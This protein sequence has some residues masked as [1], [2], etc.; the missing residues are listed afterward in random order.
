MKRANAQRRADLSGPARRFLFLGSAMS[1]MPAV[2]MLTFESH[3]WRN[4]VCL[5]WLFLESCFCRSQRGFVGCEL[6][7]ARL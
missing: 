5:A 6:D 3:D 7:L 1:P 2:A 4:A